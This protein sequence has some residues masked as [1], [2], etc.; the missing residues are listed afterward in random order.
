M[1]RGERSRTKKGEADDSRDGNDRK[2]E[3][4]LPS[5]YMYM[6]MHVHVCKRSLPHM[7]TSIH[8]NTDMQY[9][10]LPSVKLEVESNVQFFPFLIA[11]GTMY[12]PLHVRTCT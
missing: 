7:Y 1:G 12:R 10:S 9:L 5:K 4:M 6:Y 8:T 2:G 11:A 3:Q